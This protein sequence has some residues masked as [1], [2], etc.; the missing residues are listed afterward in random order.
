MKRRRLESDIVQV[1]HKFGA[2]PCPGSSPR[3]ASQP[4]PTLIEVG[5]F[6]DLVVLD[7]NLFALPVTDIS[8][9]RVVVTMF[10]GKVVHGDLGAL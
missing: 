6:A 9:A 7:R 4:R 10:Q 2:G 8:R 3:A 5:K 1:S